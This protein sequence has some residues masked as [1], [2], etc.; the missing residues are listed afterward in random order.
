LFCSRASAFHL[1]PLLPSL[2]STFVS[3]Q[4]AN[5]DSKLSAKPEVKA[6]VWA[7][8]KAYG[9]ML[10]H[11]LYGKVRA[12]V[13]AL[14]GIQKFWN[15]TKQAKGIISGIMGALYEAD[16]LDE[17]SFKAWRDDFT[18]VFRTIPGKDRALVATTPFFEF[19]DQADEEDE[20]EEV[21]E[22]L[23]GVMRPHNATR[24]K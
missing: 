14:Y 20:D 23:K 2:R 18:E 8:P 7:G 6:N 22:A 12:A 21:L 10:A 4:K 17:E 19:L 13:S 9:P 1:L 5:E 16:I 15:E 11:F 3:L 24:L